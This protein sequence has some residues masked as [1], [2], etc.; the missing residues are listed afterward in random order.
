[1]HKVSFGSLT[2]T[3]SEN[4]Q[5]IDLQWGGIARSKWPS[6]GTHMHNALGSL[7]RIM[8]QNGQVVDLLWEEMDRSK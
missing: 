4:G 3:I 8:N 6:S 5:V 7:A 1:M 2:R